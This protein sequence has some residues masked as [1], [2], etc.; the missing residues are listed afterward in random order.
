[1]SPPTDASGSPSSSNNNNFSLLNICSKVK[2]DGTNYN[3]WMRNIKMAIRFEDKEYVL[4]R[5]LDEI[6]E[7]K[8]TP[9]EKVA[10]MKQ[11]NDATKVDCIMVATMNL[12]LQRHYDDYWPY[13]MNKDL[14]EKYYK[15]AR[16][17][18]YEV[19]KSLIAS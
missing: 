19:V 12:E 14:M 17:E 3:V 7:E 18:K 1:M 2:L 16:Q 11:Y 9:E 4:E 15:W 6:H 5:P 8:A 10:Y 13:E